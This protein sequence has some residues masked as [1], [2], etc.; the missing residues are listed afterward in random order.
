MGCPGEVESKQAGGAVEPDRSY[1]G[2]SPSCPALGSAAAEREERWRS[3][4]AVWPSDA[5]DEQRRLR[6]EREERWAA[7]NGDGGSA[8][9]TG[10]GGGGA[11]GAAAGGGQGG[12]G[13]GGSGGGP[14]PIRVEHPEWPRS[15]AEDL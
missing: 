4:S 2:P 1:P 6:A 14:A 3:A 13:G 10:G 8:G 9:G 12:A 11:S 7:T 15:C 5:Y